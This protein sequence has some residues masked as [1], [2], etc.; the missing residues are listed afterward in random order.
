MYSQKSSFFPD[1]FPSFATWDEEKVS[2]KL[3]WVDKLLSYFI[4]ALKLILAQSRRFLLTVQMQECLP[5]GHWARGSWLSLANS[6][7][8]AKNHNLYINFLRDQTCKK[9][10]QRFWS[11]GQRRLCATKSHHLVTHLAITFI[12]WSFQTRLPTMKKMCSF[13]LRWSG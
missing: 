3:I 11:A 9:E 4:C 2:T 1:S 13:F 8:T 10:V 7:T 5:L 12:Q 6:G